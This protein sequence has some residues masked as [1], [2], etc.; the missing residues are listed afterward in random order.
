MYIEEDN[1]QYYKGRSVLCSF[2]LHE[3]ATTKS[4]YCIQ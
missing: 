2:T 4:D 1:L 3:S